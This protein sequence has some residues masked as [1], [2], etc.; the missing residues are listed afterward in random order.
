MDIPST[1]HRRHSKIQLYSGICFGL[2]KGLVPEKLYSRHVI[3]ATTQDHYALTCVACLPTHITGQLFGLLKRGIFLTV[4]ASMVRVVADGT[5]FCRAIRTDDAL[6]AKFYTFRDKKPRTIEIAAV[7]PVACGIL[8]GGEF[9]CLDFIQSHILGNQGKRNR[10]FAAPGRIQALIMRGSHKET[11][12]AI[13]AV[14]V[15]TLCH[16]QGGSGVLIGASAAVQLHGEF[17][18]RFGL[19]LCI[20]HGRTRFCFFI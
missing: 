4:A 17:L 19:A 18:Q 3:A 14:P 2:E 7:C 6:R 1:A 9:E 16:D 11:L 20:R 8:H 12:D 15:F 5:G 10:L 13:D